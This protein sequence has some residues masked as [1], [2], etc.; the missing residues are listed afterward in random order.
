MPAIA[1]LPERESQF[2]GL[3]FDD[4]YEALPAQPSVTTVS[5][6]KS[7]M[8]IVQ[9]DG[10]CVS[11]LTDWD[12]LRAAY[13]DVRSQM[14]SN[15]IVSGAIV[16]QAEVVIRDIDDFKADLARNHVVL[17]RSVFPNVVNGAKHF[18]NLYWASRRRVRD[19]LLAL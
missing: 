14:A 4:K 7:G 8:Q 17:H 9:I 6:K 11:I 15:D 12:M 19:G 2:A 1:D 18:I 13:E 10:L 5:G 16:F 3:Q